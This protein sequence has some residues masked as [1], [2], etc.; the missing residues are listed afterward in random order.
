MS[1]APRWPAACA[2]TSGR[3]R[4][5]RTNSASAS[6][7]RRS[8]RS[9]TANSTRRVSPCSCRSCSNSISTS[10]CLR[11]SSN[12]V[13]P[14]PQSKPNERRSGTSRSRLPATG[15]AQR[16]HP[17]RCATARRSVLGRHP[18][19]SAIRPSRSRVDDE[20][21]SVGITHRPISSGMNAST[22]RSPPSPESGAW[23]GHGS[24]R[25]RTP[26]PEVDS[27]V[28]GRLVSAHKPT[29]R[30]CAGPNFRRCSSCRKVALNYRRTADTSPDFPASTTVLG[31]RLRLWDMR[32][33]ERWAVMVGKLTATGEL[34]E[35]DD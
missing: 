14:P 29:H 8:A 23:P 21:T 31:E 26:R 15:C 18:V 12:R 30:L 20:S 11:P 35:A 13:R 4:R 7:T 25:Y 19:R 1:P 33:V 24:C 6:S 28:L 22:R 32:D 5:C 10:A 16:S 17:G 2:P 9:K 27:R 34:A 3:R